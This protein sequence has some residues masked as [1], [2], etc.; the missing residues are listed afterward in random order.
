M[1]FRGRRSSDT[2]IVY[3]KIAWPPETIK[4]RYNRPCINPVQMNVVRLS[5]AMNL[6]TCCARLLV[7]TYLINLPTYL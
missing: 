7:S 6:R 1:L 2:A 3:S 5:P 4:R